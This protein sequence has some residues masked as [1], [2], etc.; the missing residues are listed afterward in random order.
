EAG[1]GAASMAGIGSAAAVRIAVSALGLEHW[2]QGGA[3]A[4]AGPWV[5]TGWG[6]DRVTYIRSRIANV[7]TTARKPHRCSILHPPCCR[8]ESDVPGAAQVRFFHDIQ[9]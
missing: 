5:S 3:E 6:S 4:R 2:Q 1:K 7:T 9:T 8:S